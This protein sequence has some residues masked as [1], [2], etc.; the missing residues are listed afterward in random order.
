MGDEVLIVKF[1]DVLVKINLVE[2]NK[3]AHQMMTMMTMMKLEL[4]QLLSPILKSL[5]RLASFLWKIEEPGQ[6]SSK[7][8]GWRCYCLK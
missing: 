3:K 5:S 1:K 6:L 7:T 4:Q 2:H 8:V